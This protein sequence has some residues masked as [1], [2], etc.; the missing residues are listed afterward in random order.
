MDIKLVHPDENGLISLKLAV[1]NSPKKVT[2]VQKLIQIVYVLLLKTPG[3]DIIQNTN[4]G[5]LLALVQGSNIDINN[6]QDVYS[7]LVSRIRIVEAQIIEDQLNRNLDPKEKLSRINILKVNIDEGDPTRYY[8]ELE[9]INESEDTTTFI[10]P[11][12]VGEIGQ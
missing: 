4:G 8:V 12:S 10:V 7:D 5:G 9:L 3:Q 2:G 1:Y 6:L 11:I